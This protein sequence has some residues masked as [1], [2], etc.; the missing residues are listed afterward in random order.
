MECLEQCDSVVDWVSVAVDDVIH[1]LLFNMMTC[2]AYRFALVF[3]YV[4]ICE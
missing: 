2:F 3:A 1:F 4:K